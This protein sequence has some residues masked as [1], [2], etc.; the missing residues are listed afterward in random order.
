[1]PR[2][3][4]LLASLGYGSRREVSEWVRDGRVTVLGAPERDP[5]AQVAAGTVRVDSEQL[6]H[7]GELLLLMNKPAGRVCSHEQSEGATVYELLPERWRRRN[8]VITTIGRLDK[9][10]TGLLLLTDRAALVHRL[11]S[12]RHKVAKVYRATLDR[13]LPAGI[14]DVFGAGTLLLAGEKDPCAPALLTPLG[15]RQAELTLTEGRY[16]QV[17]RMFAGQGCEVLELERV[18]FGPLEIGSVARGSWIEL[19]VN[20]LDQL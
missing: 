12:P 13:D 16:H 2:L 7:P 19:P 14:G 9:E 4:Q 1:M 17:K 20:S 6:D 11:T 8:P 18:R 3:D 10:T 5:A 15:P